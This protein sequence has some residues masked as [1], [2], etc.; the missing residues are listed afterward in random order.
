M[1]RQPNHHRNARAEASSLALRL[2][3][4]GAV[5]RALARRIATAPPPEALATASEAVK[6]TITLAF[7]ARM[8]PGDLANLF[9]QL[10]AEVDA[11]AVEFGAQVRAALRK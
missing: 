5:T 4:L 8:P 7:A 10:A 9:R 2:A 11:Q 6:A 3:N 1:K